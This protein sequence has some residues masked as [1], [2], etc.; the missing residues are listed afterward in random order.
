M[1]PKAITRSHH[2]HRSERL[3]DMAYQSFNNITFNVISIGTK[4]A[5]D[6]VYLGNVTEILVKIH[7][8]LKAS[9]QRD[10]YNQDIPV[11]LFATCTAITEFKSNID[12]YIQFGLTTCLNDTSRR[13]TLLAFMLISDYCVGLK[14]SELQRSNMYK[15]FSFD[16]VASEIEK[17]LG[18]YNCSGKPLG[19][20]I[21]ECK[22][23][24]GS[25]NLS[26]AL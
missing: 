20:L 22:S 3:R 11:L 17:L 21:S 14:I 23:M 13:A 18:N 2:H 10:I 9:F 16:I 7:D 24:V 19:E 4:Y 8:K 1:F 12:K 25:A 5:N 15:G 6:K 26:G